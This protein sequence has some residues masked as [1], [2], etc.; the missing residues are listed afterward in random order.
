MSKVVKR[1]TKDG[2][3]LPDGVSE[4]KDGRF[5]YRYLFNGKPR[6]MYD[7]DL[8]SLKKKISQ[9]QLDITTGR[10]LDL[11]GM[12]LKEWYPQYIKIFKEGKVKET[13]LLNLYY[14]FKWYV[15]DYE[16]ARMPMRDLK[17]TNFIAH[18]KHLAD[19]KQLSRGT[20]RSLASM[21]FN[22][23]QQVIYDGGLY[24]NPASEIMKDIVAK[25]KEVRDALSDEQIKLL[26]DFLKIE[27][28]FQNVHL[29]MIGIL[30]GTGIRYGECAGLTWNDI[31]F[32]KKVVC[33]SHSMHYR[34][35]NDK[36]GHRY[37]ITSPKT[38]NAYRDIPLSEDMM[39]L[40][41][42]Q[43]QYQKKMKIRQDIVI[44]GRRGFIFTSRLGYP[45]TH[46]GAV[47]SI[48]RIVKR[49]NEWEEVRAKLEN[50]KPVVLPEKL[51]PHV[52]RHTFA[53]KLV[54]ADV[55]YETTKIVMGHSSI[56]TTMDI[57]AHIKHDNKKSMRA[58]IGN[59][60]SIF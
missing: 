51:T 59:V 34:C 47:A 45:Y 14:Y 5:V 24:V 46:E 15:Q 1:K 22:C 7:R 36:E 8:T 33:I 25:P 48:R 35:K 4:R 29:P 3:V 60:V 41:E 23:L 39:S 43:K 53:T 56:K 38:V 57:Y 37:F 26:L 12:S 20:L 10:N 31:D 17:R 21:L 52:F 42:L 16:I 18:F 19:E 13:T 55:P 32:E 58:D 27:G 9:L 49:A 40:L 54:L 2:R 28:T 6:Y 11:A 44:D 30:L 50:R